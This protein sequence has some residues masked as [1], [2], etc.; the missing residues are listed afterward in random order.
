MKESYAITFF[1]EFYSIDDI[2]PQD[3]IFDVKDKWYLLNKLDYGTASSH[4]LE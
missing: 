1:A 2:Y 3:Y 4:W